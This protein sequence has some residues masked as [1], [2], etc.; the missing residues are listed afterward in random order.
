M[1]EIFSVTVSEIEKQLK[2][3]ALYSPADMDKRTISENDCNR[4]GL[5]LMGF[6]E[7][8]NAERVQICGNMEFAYLASLDEK[9]RYERIDALFATKIPLFIVA[10]GHELYPEMLEIA[11]KYEVPIARTHESTTAFIAALIGYLN[12]ELAPRIT[13]H[14]VLIEVYGE[15]ILI[16]GESGVGKSE[17]AIELVK[18]GHRLVADDAVEIRKTS[19]RTLVGQSPDN[20][21][22]FLELRGIGII[23]TRRLF[24]MGAVKI[25]EKIDLIVELEPWDSEKI[26]DRMGVDN[27]YT[28]IMGIKIP[29]LTIPIK[30]GRNLAVIL[31]VAAMNNRQKKM[32][33]NAASEL[34]QKLGLDMDTT[35][36]EKNW[37][38]F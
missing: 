27:Q 11:K 35:E 28:N 23:N 9:T 29:S 25:S 6:Y 7:Y 19:N 15:G 36:T 13:R 18:R 37:D 17:T 21:R 12:V 10:R 5:Q 14:G 3:E 38:E 1:A 31:E 33:Y 8:F 20:I 26:Y 34:L 4:P 22:H 16:V 30:P 2:L 24:G 32:G